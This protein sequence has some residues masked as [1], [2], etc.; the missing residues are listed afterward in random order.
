MYLTFTAMRY[1]AQ[2]KAIW[3]IIKLC[4]SHKQQKHQT[5]GSTLT[6][7]YIDRNMNFKKKSWINWKYRIYIYWYKYDLSSSLSQDAYGAAWGNV[8]AIWIF[9][10]IVLWILKNKKKWKKG[11]RRPEP[12][13]II[14]INTKNNEYIVG[15]FDDKMSPTDA[16]NNGNIPRIK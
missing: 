1:P 5:N 14:Y 8:W 9:K 6:V 16:E 10:K 11:Q 3:F 7:Q 12:D 2:I 15:L 13:I 4:V